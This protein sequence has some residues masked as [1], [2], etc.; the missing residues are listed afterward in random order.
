MFT[1]T[2]LEFTLQ[3]T[4]MNQQ[5]SSSVRDQGKISIITY[6]SL[7]ILLSFSTMY[8]C[9]AGIFSYT[10]TKTTHCKMVNAEPDVTI[11]PDIKEI[12]Q[13]VKNNVPLSTKL[14]FVLEKYFHKDIF[15]STH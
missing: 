13:N 8:L 10:L 5:F 2:V 9:E 11:Q 6:K 12:C 1:D 15:V 3:L 4:F 14:I 7:K